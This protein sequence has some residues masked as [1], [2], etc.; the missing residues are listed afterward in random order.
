MSNLLLSESTVLETLASDPIQWTQRKLAQRT[1]YSI[2]LINTIVKKL[3]QNGYI[4]IVATDG[5]R[6][7]YL[8]T[9]QGLAAA[10]RVA[11]NYI[12]RTVR[13]YEQIYVQIFNFFQNLSAQGHQDLCV[14]Y[15][16][17]ELK[18]L[19]HVVINDCGVASKLNLHDCADGRSR[20]TRVHLKGATVTGAG[21]MLKMTLVSDDKEAA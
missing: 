14:S 13:D 5:R 7:N 10:S 11:S 12:L 2:G 16:D 8:L 3:T 17:P 19:L 1:G 21:P 9:P 4:Q 15:A 6:V 20:L 18:R